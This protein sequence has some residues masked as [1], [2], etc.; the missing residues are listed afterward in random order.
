MKYY[1][2]LKKIALKLTRHH[3][4]RYLILGVIFTIFTSLIMGILVDIKGFPSLLIYIP[5]TIFV[6][7]IKYPIYK[8]VGLLDGRGFIHYV[9]AG[10]LIF[11]ILLGLSSLLVWI[12]VDLAGFPAFIVSFLAVCVNFVLRFQLYKS[13]KIFKQL[14]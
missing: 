3:F 9:F 11:F 13:F 8:T 12:F 14:T 4:S 6:F 1:T 10:S 7:L 2:E 5:L